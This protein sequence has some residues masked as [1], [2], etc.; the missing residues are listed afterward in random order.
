VKPTW[1]VYGWLCAW[2]CLGVIAVLATGCGQDRTALAAG[3]NVAPLPA[4]PHA[5]DRELAVD[6][7]AI[8][9][10]FSTVQQP[11]LDLEST[12]KALEARVNVR[13]PS[14]F[15]LGDLAEAYIHRAQ[16]SGDASDYQRAVDLAKQ[17][18]AQLP[19]GNGAVL[20]LAKVANARHQF[21]DAIN[22]AEG[23]LHQKPSTGA[24][25]LIATAALALGDLSRASAEADTAVTAKPDSSTHE[26]RALVLQAQGRDAEAAYDFAHSIAL[27]QPGDLLE[28]AR[29]RTMWARFLLRR[30][31]LAGARALLDEALRISP[32]HPLAL[33]NRAELDLRTGK[34]AEARAGFERAF[35]LSR[36]V[37]Y[38]IDLARAQELAGDGAAATSTRAQ[39]EK[40]VRADLAENG[41]GHKLDLVETLA[42]RGTPADLIEAVAL[43]R[44]E[45]DHRPSAD[46]RFQLAR[47]L[48]L[49]GVPGAVEDARTQI[50]AA[51]AS[52]ARDARF[53][54]LAARVE[55]GPRRALYAHEAERLD[56]G[57]S[58]WRKLGMGAK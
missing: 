38:L 52:G 22:I 27:E 25:V 53:Y 11:G 4:A 44:E 6:P 50:Q 57:N 48:Y 35:A 32:D 51:L 45:L 7:A 58:G 30:G 46:T 56:P 49:S 23:F 16:V 17:S 28:A 47:A 41:V 5:S 14:P 43:A 13:V 21:T 34:L 24:H 26:M 54:E 8:R 36:Q 40:F 12:I 29:T 10:K 1:V 42:D 18:L 9:Y 31:E 37:R 20:I 19:E 2:L 39:V 15:D 3:A 33:A 55:S